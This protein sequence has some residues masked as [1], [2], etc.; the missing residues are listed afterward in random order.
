MCDLCELVGLCCCCLCYSCYKNTRDVDCQCCKWVLGL[1]FTI[2]TII[3]NI[4][5]CLVWFFGTKYDF[6][7]NL[8]ISEIENSFQGELIE[9]ISIKEICEGD[10]EALSIG[11]WDGTIEGCECG[12]I[13][14]KGICSSDQINNG[15]TSLYSNPPK[16]YNIFNSS[17]LCAKRSS[18]KY[19]QL[20]KTKQ[21]I[22]KGES[23]PINY[24][25]C[26]ILDTLGRELCREND[27]P[28]PITVDKIQFQ[29]FNLYNRNKSIL[30]KNNNYLINDN[31]TKSILISQ[32]KIIQFQPCI[33][34]NEK[35]WNYYY[36]LEPTDKRCE[37]KI[38]GILY[39]TRYE[40]ISNL[41]I[42]KLQLYDDNLITPKLKFIDGT[43]LNRIL[44]DIVNLFAINFWGF[45]I[46]E[47]EN[48]GFNYEKILGKVKTIQNCF[49]ASIIYSG[50]MILP[51]FV[52]FIFLILKDHKVSVGPLEGKLNIKYILK[53]V[54]FLGILAF[55]FSPLVLIIIFGI[56]LDKV[57]SI[58]SMLNFKICD[59]FTVELLGLLINECSFDF[60]YS[61]SMVIINVFNF[62]LF[63]YSLCNMPDEVKKGL[64][65]ICN[66]EGE[67]N[68]F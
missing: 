50:I 43:S 10:E 29:I 57:R 44:K 53:I 8:I 31:Q 68:F 40:K 14:F 26:G 27:K 48:S 17:F 55:L 16:D 41:S 42:N 12:G 52:A 9:S 19:I 60:K 58:K 39:D 45:D 6:N 7:N 35:F 36:I 20:L 11:T 33:N 23:C 46:D 38:N 28:C 59:K 5:F 2:V 65:D 22:L 49:Y 30:A 62:I 63:Y 56:I 15:C 13:I 37:T 54:M 66:N 64:Y 51:I 67:Y 4:I 3:I 61:L 24:R 18:L 21:V 32:L 47:M 25:S 1:F 34:P